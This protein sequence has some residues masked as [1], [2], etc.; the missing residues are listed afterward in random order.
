MSQDAKDLICAF[1]TNR[2][3]HGNDKKKQPNTCAF[4]FLARIQNISQFQAACHERTAVDTLM[5]S[6]SA[7]DHGRESLQVVTK[8]WTFC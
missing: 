8:L 7:L 5:L 4:V 6:F 3:A 2:F 1:L